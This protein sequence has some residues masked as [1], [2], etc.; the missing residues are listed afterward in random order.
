MITG[1]PFF[2][3]VLP[4]HASADQI[5]LVVDQWIDKLDADQLEYFR[6]IVLS[7]RNCPQDVK[8]RF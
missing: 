4:A 3:R 7:L 1:N 6:L 5:R 2:D 8:E